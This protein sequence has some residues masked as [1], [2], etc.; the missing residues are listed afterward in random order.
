MC[1]YEYVFSDLCLLKTELAANILKTRRLKKS[2]GWGRRTSGFRELASLLEASPACCL[3]R[4]TSTVA[5]D[6]DLAK[7]PMDEQEC[8]L[9]LESCEC[10]SGAGQG[11]L[12]GN[13][14]A[15]GEGTRAAR[16]LCSRPGSGTGKRLG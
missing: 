5:C 4:I 2:G 12:L 13:C 14:A 6:M 16:D 3:G 11:A 7:Y 1:M 8:M 15:G 9:H 10:P